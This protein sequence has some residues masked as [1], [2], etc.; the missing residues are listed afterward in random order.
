MTGDGSY[1]D[2][3]RLRLNRSGLVV[4][5][6]DRFGGGIPSF[7]GRVISTGSKI[8]VGKF[9]LV[10]P[11]FVLGAEVEGG[12]GSLTSMPSETVP[13]FLL[14]PGLPSTGDFLVCRFVDHR[15]AA[16]RST[17]GRG[18]QGIYGTIPTCFCTQ[19][20][21]TLTMTS[22]D[23]TCNY[24]MFQSCTIQYG[25]TP[26]QFS[27]L[28]LGANIFLST[29]SFPDPISGGAEFFYYLICHLNQF[30]LTRIYPT[31]PYGS[32]FR[33]AILYTWLLGGYGNTCSPFHLDNGTA[34]PGSDLSC[35]VTIDQM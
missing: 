12:P 5:D 10:Q 7:V 20:P 3:A 17:S 16:E 29:E 9:L 1:D 24:R 35:S 28:N 8:A 30:S 19:I 6:T 22:A 15:W 26:A 31:S 21:A 18:P 11:S 25:P 34:F 13:V 2:F 32:P 33:D 27:T 14:G 23:P 4:F